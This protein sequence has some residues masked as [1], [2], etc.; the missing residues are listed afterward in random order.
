ME[1]SK[2]SNPIFENANFLII[3]VVEY[4]ENASSYLKHHNVLSFMEIV[5]IFTMKMSTRTW[6]MY[7]IQYSIRKWLLLRVGYK[8]CLLGSDDRNIQELNLS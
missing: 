2:S 7:T 6:L 1:P 5:I 4:V 3:A 8:R